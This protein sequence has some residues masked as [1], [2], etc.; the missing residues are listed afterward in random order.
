MAVTGENSLFFK[1]GLDNSGLQQGST[2]AVGIVSNM[3]N[4]IAKINPFIGLAIGATTAFAIIGKQA[5]AMAKEFEHAMKEVETISEATQENFDKIAADVFAISKISPDKP[6][7]LAEAYYQIVSAGYDGSK[8]LKLLEQSS[9]A[10]I[11][12]V[13]D[14][15]T[16]ADGLT[17]VMNAFNIEIGEASTVSDVFFNTVRLGK[18]TFGELSASISQVAPLASA[19]GI[20]YEEIFSAVASL[21]KQGVPTAQAMTQIRSA[22]IALSENL[23]DGWAATMTFQEGLQALYDKAGGSQ[24]E[25]KELTGRVEA[26][27]AVLSLSGKNFKSANEDL[28]SFSKTVGATSDAFETMVGDTTNQWALFGN[29]MRSTIEG[30]GNTLNA[31]SGVFATIL[32]SMFSTASYSGDIVKQD[33]RNLGELRAKLENTNVSYDEKLEILK[34]LKSEYPEYLEFLNL[35]KINHQ[36]LDGALEQVRTKLVEINKLL[37]KRKELSAYFDDAKNAQD[38]ADDLQKDH[39][40]QLAYIRNLI[41]DAREIAE[42]KGIKIKIGYV[43][44]IEEAQKEFLKIE[45]AFATFNPFADQNEIAINLGDA[46]QVLVNKYPK[47]QEAIAKAKKEAELLQ[48]ERIVFLDSEDGS[49]ELKK[50]VSEIKEIKGLLPLFTNLSGDAK[51]FVDTEIKLRNIKAAV[52]SL[53]KKELFNDDVIA[54]MVRS[55]SALGSKYKQ[56]V[57]DIVADRKKLIVNAPPKDLFAESLDKKSEAYQKYALAIKNKDEDL[58][59]DLKKLYKLKEEDYTTYLQNLYKITSNIDSKSL[60]LKELEAAGSGLTRDR[61][62]PI[63]TT[64]KGIVKNIVIDKDLESYYK[65]IDA[66]EDKRRKSE[67]NA[68]YQE[69]TNQIDFYRKKILLIEGTARKEIELNEDVTFQLESMTDRQLMAYIASTKK[70]LAAT[71]DLTSE[72]KNKLSANIEAAEVQRFTN[73]IDIIQTNLSQVSDM[74]RKVGDDAT[75]DMLDALSILAEG[76]SDLWSKVGKNMTSQDKFAVYAQAATTILGV[77]ISSSEQRKRA[78]ED[79]YHS[80]IEQQKEYNQLLNDQ[81]RLRESPTSNV[82]T[83][84]YLNEIESGIDALRDATGGYLKALEDLEDG[85]AKTGTRNRID[86]SAVATTTGAGAAVGAVAGAGV[87]SWLGA[88]IGAVGGFIVGVIGGIKKDARWNGLLQEYPELLVEMEN[89]QVK[90]NEELAKTLINQGLVNKK[91]RIL[92]EDALEWGEKVKEAKEQIAGVISE[93]AG[94]LGTDLSDALVTAFE[95]GTDAAEAMGDSIEKVLENILEHL[96][97]NAIFSSLFDDLEE[98]MTASWDVK[99]GGD[100]DISDDLGRFFEKAQLKIDDFYKALGIAQDLAGDWDLDIFT[101][102]SSND[103]NSLS[104][105]IQ[106]ITE[107]TAEVLAGTLNAIR[108]DVREGLNIAESS[109][110]QLTRIGDNTEYNQ[111]L[112]GIANTLVNIENSLS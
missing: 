104:G 75:A 39:D 68:Q 19:T 40:K 37:L 106:N 70:K 2:N 100:G 55:Y 102:D 109:L 16:A 5:Y 107:N 59:K 45:K 36:N 51:A 7:A 12:G 17:T 33:L 103:P 83:K 69:Y 43:T 29:H 22:I 87:F 21:T 18:T 61:V 99:G 50:I 77:I 97:F 15:K 67:T 6:K 9:K 4:S 46:L 11:A 56:I 8:G 74:F 49:E 41:K 53:S 31:M 47:L 42:E 27:N 92:I 80:V 58:A 62:D 54:S 108:I 35:D 52:E 13:T 90:L 65:R 32:N 89:G 3:A 63:E 85:E 79:Y 10:A 64:T 30:L 76:V 84:D 78:D 82:F 95:N 94:S 86:W 57:L 26:M 88:A 66:I 72:Q 101:P 48:N 25:L 34:K 24:N 93:L 14:T 23:G 1:T 60:I 105:S 112:E 38:E 28:A 98:E 110:A 71:E 91:G 20:A 81:I 96:I 111:N 44:N 73:L